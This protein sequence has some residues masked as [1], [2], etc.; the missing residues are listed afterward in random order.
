MYQRKGLLVFRLEN[1]REQLFWVNE[2]FLISTKVF[3][4]SLTYFSALLLLS[5]LLKR[6]IEK[7]SILKLQKVDKCLQIQQELIV[8]EFV[9]IKKPFWFMAANPVRSL[10]ESIRCP[11]FLLIKNPIIRLCL[12][13]FLG[14]NAFRKARKT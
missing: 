7:F 10:L 14:T 9:L 4:H 5:S 12:H 13:Q 1:E 3:L 6:G 2:P 8:L 11:V